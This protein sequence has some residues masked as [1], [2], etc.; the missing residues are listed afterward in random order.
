MILRQERLKVG[1]VSPDT[2]PVTARRRLV[3]ALALIVVAG[4]V[5]VLP[6]PVHAAAP[7]MTPWTLPSMPPNCTTT[8]VAS[9][10]VASCLVT[11][12]ASTPANRGWPVPPFPTPSTEPTTW[13]DVAQ[14]ST[15]TTVVSIQTALRARGATLAA[16]G[17]FGPITAAAV[18][19]FQTTSGLPATGVVDQ[20][21][22][23]ALGVTAS[24][25]PPTGWN[26]LGWTYNG[27]AALTQWETQLVAP[28]AA[29]GPVRAANLRTL[30]DALPLFEG[31]VRDIVAGGYSIRE[32]GTYVFRCT[33]NTRKDCQGLAAGSL[34]NHSWGLAID[35]NTAAN[36]ELTYSGV[37]GATACA[38]PQRTDIPM[39]VV[40][41]AERW[42]LYWGGYGWNGGCATPTQV[43]TSILR[44]PMHFEFRGTPE[45]ARAIATYNASTAPAPAPT[46]EPPAPPAA[47][48]P[49]RIGVCVDV[50]DASGVITERCLPATQIPGAGTRT[51]IDT[52]A[53]AGAAAA[54]VNITL[55]DAPGGG[56]VT[57]ESCGAIP[58][59]V[60]SWSNVNVMPARVRANLATVPLDAA[61]RFCLYQS[62]PMHTIVDVQ[63]FYVPTATAPSANTFHLVTPDRVADSRTMPVCPPVGSCAPA[64]LVAGSSETVSPTFKV[65][66]TA[67]ATVA[68]LTIVEATAPGY[69]SADRCSTLVPGP[70]AFSNLNFPVAEPVAN[71]VVVPNEVTAGVSNFC[72]FATATAHRIVDVQGY[73]APAATGGWSYGT[74]T[75][76]RLIDTRRGAINQAGSIIRIQGPAGASAAL[77]NL[78][79]TG[80]TAAGY[81]TAAPCS[82]LTSGPQSNSNGNVMPGQDVANLAIV[83]LDPDGSFCVFTSSPMHVIADLQGAF[84]TGEALRYVPSAPARRHD[85]RV[86]NA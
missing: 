77:V 12:S 51:V 70:Q 68:N 47:P 67:V 8:Q 71:L 41:A 38:T 21:T 74:R 62:S 18:Q 17:V 82:K 76:E 46:P 7:D 50:A 24:V 25:F 83:G 23:T 10:N 44:D 33:S 80:A 35:M 5:T 78:T 43:K 29:I 34:S 14:G 56:Y 59:G 48:A 39:W 16:D 3:P 27:S 6:T 40:R 22:A 32:A 55:T 57:A 85:S 54:L 45:Q 20:A 42:G 58:D 31:F 19:S 36:P 63:G 49:P 9:G 26:W 84:G 72:S 81:V 4:A 66:T 1:R 2:S 37:G 75:A 73:F 53:P 30:P 61:G 11:N 86:G 79:L 28:A 13:T 52:G 15:G 69:L 64:G 65:P 60:R